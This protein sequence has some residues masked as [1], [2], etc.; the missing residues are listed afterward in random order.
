MWSGVRG[1]TVLGAGVQYFG[2]YRITAVGQG[3]AETDF[4]GILQGSSWVAPQAHLDLNASR[5]FRLGGSLREV[6]VDIVAVNLLDKSPPREVGVTTGAP[7]YSR[8]GDPRRR[9]FDIVLSSGF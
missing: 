5:R 4:L 6:R 8:Y 1:S 2:K 7:G 9:R 3:P